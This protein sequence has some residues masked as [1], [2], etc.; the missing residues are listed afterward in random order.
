MPCYCTKEQWDLLQ[1][2]GKFKE[3]CQ[4]FE[5]P[6]VPRYKID[7]PDIDF[8]V[9]TKPTDG[10]GSSGFSVCNDFNE[11]QKG[12]EKAAEC[13]PTSNV[14]IEKFVKNDSVVV[15]YTISDGKI[16][17]SGL[18][19]K[20]PVKYTE[21]GSYVAGLHIWVSNLSTE[22]RNLFEEKLQKLVNYIDIKSGSF[23]IEVFHDDNNYYFN[24]V[25][26]RYGGSVSIFPVNYF[27][28]INQVAADIYYALTGKCLVDGFPSLI[29]ETVP[30]KKHYSVLNL[31][32][33]SGEISEIIGLD[34]IRSLPECVF[35]ADTKKIGD[36]V[37]SSG[38]VSQVFAFVHF[39]FETFDECRGFVDKVYKTI[40]VK[41]SQGE[42]MIRN[43]LDWNSPRLVNNLTDNKQMLSVKVISQNDLIKAG[44]FNIP[45]TL[46]IVEQ[47]FIARANNNVIFPDKVSVIF[48]ERTQNRINCLPAGIPSE[49]VYGMK[50]VSVFPENPKLYGLQNLSAVIVLSE[51][52]Y[53][54]PKAFMEGTLCSNLRTGATSA[55][56]AKYL[57]KKDSEVIG[58][59]GAGEQA[60][61]HLMMMVSALPSLKTC[62]VSSRTNESE[63]KFIKQLSKMYPNIQFIACNSD[64]EKAA[65]DS[66]VIVTAI[67]GQEKIL[68]GEWVSSGAL[69]CHVG[70]LEDDYSVAK[71]ANKIVC[72]DWNVVKHRTQTISRM[73][74]EGLLK[75]ENIYGNLDAIVTGKLKGR[76]SENEIIYFNTVGM[77][78][79]DVMLSNSM[80]K[81]VQMKGLGLD[82]TL[83]D[84]S[85]FDIEESF[86]VK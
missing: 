45:E 31:H 8:P 3:L 84:K 64:Y 72:D 57:A 71:K 34:E 83:Q 32:M 10:C 39:V 61:F 40:H 70:G 27:Y 46:R 38:T 13:S 16:V 80:Y 11:L 55:V 7:T 59:I 37:K 78:Y 69:Y 73:Y 60:K 12:Y 5:L 28:G 54:F 26:F 63:K 58:F 9:I 86:I 17:F 67:S 74:K 49:S 65:R 35:I 23:W 52:K 29:S 2:K 33:I 24:E 6:C 36:V 47:A 21:Q 85:I 43:M 22:F 48:D 62:K 56:A 77:S 19:D 66:D 75:D 79:V 51:L 41:N 20:Y 42:E 53:G 82:I 81:K 44:C 4:K 25:G 50:W 68:K 1:D 18:Q 14:L 15:F 30:H 76:E